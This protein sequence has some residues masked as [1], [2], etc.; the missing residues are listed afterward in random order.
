[1]VDKEQMTD[2]E[3]EAYTKRIRAEVDRVMKATGLPREALVV[4]RDAG[5]ASLDEVIEYMARR[6]RQKEN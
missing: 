4:D 1:M 2:A 6:D 3:R 5:N